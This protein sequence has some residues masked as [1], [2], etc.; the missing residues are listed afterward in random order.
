MPTSFW[1]V[2]ISL[3]FVI[4]IIAV[5]LPGS[6]AT[7]PLAE[8]SLS[9]AQTPATLHYGVDGRM[10]LVDEDMSLLW[11][12]NP[13]NGDYEQFFLTSLMDALPDGAGKIWWTD[14]AISFGYIDL[15]AGPKKLYSWDAPQPGG[16]SPSIGPLAVISDQIWMATWYSPSFGVYR[17]TPGNRELCHYLTPGGS[18]A[19]DLVV[20]GGRLWW[21]NW[22][23]LTVDTLMG[24]NPGDG[25]LVSYSLERNINPGAGMLVDG[26]YLW[27]AEDTDDGK[28]ARFNTT[29]AQMTLFS[30]TAGAHPVKVSASNGGIW[31]TDASGSFGR[32]DSSNA[33]GITVTLSAPQQTTITPVCETLGIAEQAN[34]TPNAGTLAWSTTDRTSTQ[35]QTWLEVISLPAS[36]SPSGIA[37]VGNS[38]WLSDPGRDKLV[39]LDIQVEHKV[40]IPLV[41]K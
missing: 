24:L 25:Q 11:R 34:I 5:P 15:N 36:A 14:G 2:I 9:P 6:G 13:A 18:Y 7:V 33:T 1:K 41:R 22:K 30:L 17:F 10:Y 4:Y 29:N 38:I 16:N 26:D 28:I 35:P 3:I 31:Y 27:W 37:A 8:A 21:L 23:N 39:R 32:L 12:I 19:T 40:F 20:L